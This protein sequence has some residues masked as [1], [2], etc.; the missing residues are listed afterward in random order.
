MIVSMLELG[1]FIWHCN[2]RASVFYPAFS[3][4]QTSKTITAEILSY[5]IGV[6]QIPRCSFMTVASGVFTSSHAIN[7]GNDGILKGEVSLYC[8][9]PVW[10]VWNKLYDNW[11]F[12]FLF[13]KQTNPNQS[14][15]RSMV[16]WYLPFS[17]PCCNLPQWRTLWLSTVRVVSWSCP[18][19]LGKYEKNNHGG[20]N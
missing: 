3:R 11:Q 19:I 20:S 15:R 5:I 1:H 13:A 2:S 8:W 18:H 12:L 10:L 16:H 4:C 7:Q 9:R 6:V 14:N 17:I